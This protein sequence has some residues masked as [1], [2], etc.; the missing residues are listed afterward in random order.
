MLPIQKMFT[1]FNYSI[2]KEKAKF[3][4]LHDVG[5]VSTAKDNANFFN[6]QDRDS[7]ADFFVDST[8]IYQIIDYHIHYSWAIGDGHN[9]YLKSNS[10]SL[11]IEMCLEANHLPSAQTIKNTQDLIRLLMAE[12]NIPL[13]NVITHHMATDKNC[14]A[15]LN[16]DGKWTKWTAFHNGI[17]LPIK[18][19]TVL[20]KPTVKPVVVTPAKPTVEAKKIKDVQH[21]LNILKFVGSNGAMLTEDGGNGANTLYAIKEFQHRMGL[22]ADGILGDLTI[23]AMNHILSDRP[24]LG[25]AYTD[26]IGTRYVQFRL[27]MVIDGVFGSGTANGVILFQKRYKLVAD[28]IV[29]QGTWK[30]LIG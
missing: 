8:S 1:K 29:G 24:L 5:N 4:V 21:K 6:K 23:G 26:R 15:S 17:V 30:V 16:T 14:P 12:L 20:G 22:T 18:N 27:G 25:I 10:N 11:S 9:K 28:G 7:S 19:V 3:I 13:A 2:R